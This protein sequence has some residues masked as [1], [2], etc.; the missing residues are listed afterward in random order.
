MNNNRT[1]NDPDDPDE[2]DSRSGDVS[3]SGHE[4]SSSHELLV[5][6]VSSGASASASSSS[7]SHSTT[8]S[9]SKRSG[10]DMSS[11]GGSTGTGGAAA[12]TAAFTRLLGNAK[13]VVLVIL[14]GLAGLTAWVWWTLATQYQQDHY[15]AVFEKYSTKVVDTFLQRIEYRV[16]A[17]TSLATSLSIQSSDGSS[18]SSDFSPI[19]N[20]ARHVESTRRLTQ[21]DTIWMAPWL[22]T[23]Q[24]KIAFEDHVAS[25]TTVGELEDATST[26]YSFYKESNW[27]N[28]DGLYRFENM[29]AVALGNTDSPPPYAPIWQV[30]S[31]SQD[32]DNHLVLFDQQTEEL[33][34]NV[35]QQISQTMMIQEGRPQPLFSASQIQATE[36]SLVNAYP[37]GPHVFLYAPI[38]NVDS[39]T[40]TMTA[41]LTLDLSWQSFWQGSIHGIPQ[42]LT[43][44]LYSS[45]GAE[46]TNIQEEYTFQLGHDDD[47]NDNANVNTKFIKSGV[48]IFDSTLGLKVETL[49]EEFVDRLGVVE[50]ED[51]IC[52]YRIGVYPT[53]EMEEAYLTQRPLMSGIALGAIFVAVAVVFVCYD[54]F[55]QM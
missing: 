19:S 51:E 17:A 7:R 28:Q 1:N 43:V 39:T 16:T 9:S 10:G 4:G 48:H 30:A 13:I 27:A 45:C 31:A 53:R 32:Q 36:D 6:V 11:S 52:Q 41:T 37:N 15:Q 21:A 20:F 3:S 25:Y 23:V 33:R 2:D 5:G 54:H 46:P 29:T 49:F 38:L 14:L 47:D 44:V 24:G 35:L 55:I 8:T 26:G 34:A 18:S 50:D 42:P 12:A 22:T 40:N